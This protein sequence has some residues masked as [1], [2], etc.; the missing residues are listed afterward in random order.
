MKQ[1]Q[2]SIETLYDELER[3]RNARQDF[4][5][6][7]RSLAIHTANNRSIIRVA[8]NDEVLTYGVTELAHRQIAD[9]LKIPFGY[10]E[11]M[12]NEIPELLDSNVNNW[13][14]KNPEKRMLRTLDGGL[15][16]FLSDRYRRLDNLELLDHVLPVIGEMKGAQVVSCD[17]T[18][19]HLY[20]KV[21][22]KSLK[23]E[24]S[25]GD[26]VQAGFVISNSE[27]G[28]GALKVEPLVFRLV[29]KNGLINRDYSHKKYHTGRQVENTDNCYELYSEETLAAD[30]K[31]YFLKVQDIV[32]SAVDEAKFAL[33]VD[34]MRMAK[35]ISTGTN[36]MQTV[37]LLGDRYILNQ[38]ERGNILRHFLIGGDASLYGL[39]NAVTRASQ[40]I[41]DYNRATEFERLGGQ[42]LEEG[43]AA[44]KKSGT[45]LM[46]PKA[47]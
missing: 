20:L 18:E 1:G 33:T 16:A 39:T 45:M 38:A 4:I 27:V 43:I 15:R 31:A 47:V 14:S 46:L 10:Y 19:T 40:D 3:Q 25:V 37:E 22:N 6:D 30:D 42:L 29:C 36:P 28:L 12:R 8:G 34:K 11:R 7:T 41:T 2:R 9:R 24:V 17:V 35:E 21:I 32:R 23:A 13:L 44:N 5:A 26:V